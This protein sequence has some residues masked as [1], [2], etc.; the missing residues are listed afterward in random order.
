MSMSTSVLNFI[1]HML[2]NDSECVNKNKTFENCIGLQFITK[3]NN[4]EEET[5]EAW[6]W[7]ERKQERA[8]GTGKEW[9]PAR[10]GDLLRAPCSDPAE[11]A[12]VPSPPVLPSPLIC[13]PFSFYSSVHISTCLIP[14]VL[15]ASKEPLSS[16]LPGGSEPALLL[17]VPVHGHACQV[18]VHPGRTKSVKKRHED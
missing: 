6:K 10:G 2:I 18:F 12:S 4:C 16:S 8:T 7:G 17:L 13:H 1:L 5:K 3:V 11:P 14:C 9:L 15:P